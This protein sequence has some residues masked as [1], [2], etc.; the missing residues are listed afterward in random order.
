MR[1]V[2]AEAARW[3]RGAIVQIPANGAGAIYRPALFVFELEGGGLAWVEPSY[4]D[5]S[6]ASAPAVHR[7]GQV[8]DVTPAGAELVFFRGRGAGWDAVVY[9]STDEDD[10]GPRDALAWGLWQLERMGTTWAKERERL[11]PIVRAG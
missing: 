11:A 5:P 6:G 3:E 9:P 2:E 8:E 10:Q 4:L 1:T 7:L